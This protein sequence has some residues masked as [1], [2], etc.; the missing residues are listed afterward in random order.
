MLVKDTVGVEAYPSDR[1]HSF[2]GG[3]LV[4]AYP[5]DDLN[6]FPTF[7]LISS[8]RLR[9][10]CDFHIYMKTSTEFKRVTSV[11]SARVNQPKVKELTV[12]VEAYPSGRA[13]SFTGR[14]LV[15]AYPMDDLSLFPIFDLIPSR[16][17]RKGCD[18]E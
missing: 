6:L 7:N 11:F 18:F 15:P 2:T 9:R 10:G 8:R 1:A 16:R 17:L 3:H 12:G 13:Q 14:H 5:M 4:P